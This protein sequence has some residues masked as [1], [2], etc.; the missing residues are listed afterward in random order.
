MIYIA[1]AL[2]LIA[3]FMAWR[4][5]KKNEALRDRLTETNSNIY[6][7]RRELVET[8]EKAQHEMT[9]LRFEMLK[10][11]G[12]L[13]VTSDMTIDQILMTHP[14]AEQVLG[15]FHIGG[16]SSCATDGDQ[17]LDLTLASS[18]QPVE[19][20]LVALNG[21]LAEEQKNGGVSTDIL[22]SPNVE[23]SF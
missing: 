14:M 21:L 12:E 20:V 19:P 22:K 1:Y 2:T 17:R 10:A 5:N 6:K 23:L 13:Q 9:K 8:Q 16:C 15:G 11:Q 18:G 3:I 7:V 4:A